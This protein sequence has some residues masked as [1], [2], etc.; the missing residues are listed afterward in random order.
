MPNAPMPPMPPM[1]MPMPDIP[2]FEMTWR[3]PAL[4]IEGES[5]GAQ[6]AEFF[7]VQDGVLVKAVIKTRPRKRPGSKPATSSSKWT[8]PK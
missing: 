8:I 6:L 1:P 7:G 3:N 2:K 4:G 5:I